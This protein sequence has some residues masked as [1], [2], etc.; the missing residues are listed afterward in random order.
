M[1]YSTLT[2]GQKEGYA[3]FIDL[4]TDPDK[5]AMV[6]T[7]TAGTGKS[8]LVKYIIENYRDECPNTPYQL[9]LTATTNKAC[10]NLQYI[11]G[12]EVQTIQS[13]LGLRVRT[14]Y[15]TGVSSLTTTNNTQMVSGV[16][17]MIDEVS[18]MDSYLLTLVNTYVTDSKILYIGDPYQILNVGTK[19][20]PVFVAGLPTV[21]LTETVRHMNSISRLSEQLKETVDTGEWGELELDN[22]HIFTMNSEEFSEAIMKE[23]DRY[24][25]RDADSKVLAWTNK[26][27]NAYNHI[28]SEHITGEPMLQ[29]GDYA[30]CNSYIRIGKYNIKTDQSVLITH[31]TPATEFGV[32]GHY[33]QLNNTVSAFMPISLEARNN[34]LKLAR[35]EKDWRTV[36]IIT[37]SW[38]DLR[39]AYACTVDKSQGST[40]KTVFIDL[41]D[42]YKCTDYSRLAR[43]VFVAASRASEKVI[44][45]TE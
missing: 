8:T 6:L 16:I 20:A 36:R 4:L 41:P 34:R 28:I 31:M 9:V 12:H 44:F 32:E 29:V 42:I 7:G 13:F 43:M 39:A 14:D 35:A 30:V 5:K 21:K 1:E 24:D 45:L 19:V 2:Q 38:I 33:T 15:T 10:E 27:V 22:E 17:L 37:D 11:T 26:Q 25:W 3:A 23:F 18:R 40:Y